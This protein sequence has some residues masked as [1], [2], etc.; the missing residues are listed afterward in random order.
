MNYLKLI[1]LLEDE[2]A[3]Q[4]EL[5]ALL[6]KER[7][8]LVKLNQDELDLIVE[9]KSQVLSSIEKI[10]T[11]RNALLQP[12]KEQR[13]DLKLSH[14]IPLCPTAGEK[15]R[16][17]KTV[18]DLRK[19]TTEITR[20]NTENSKLT[21]QVL[22]VVSSAISIIASAPEEPAPGYTVRGNI[23]KSSQPGDLSTRRG[24]SRE[25]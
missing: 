21:A 23:P 14:L 9:K 4:Q 3:K 11:S 7:V 24:I 6:T 16:L 22:G 25:A 10:A 18:D 1:K 20:M 13:E 17:T 12:L 2:A 15:A 5:L 8:A 19:Q